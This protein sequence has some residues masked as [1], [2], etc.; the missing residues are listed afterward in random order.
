MAALPVA[1]LAETPF[2]VVLAAHHAVGSS[3]V[4]VARRAR[5]EKRVLLE[6][7]APVDC[8]SNLV[9]ETLS[10]FLVAAG[11]LDLEASNAALSRSVAAGR[12]LGEL[13]VEEGS[14][15]ADDLQR[16]LQQNLA[17]KL[18]DLFT[19]KDGEMRLESGEH[20]SE[21]GQRLKVQRLIVTGVERFMPQEAIDRCAA[22]FAGALLARAPGAEAWRAEVRPNAPEAALLDVLST[23]RR[24]DELI[25]FTGRPAEEIVRSIVA[26]ALV[27]LIA[28]EASLRPRRPA[29]PARLLPPGPRPEAVAAAEAAVAA[30]R[31]AETARRCESVERAHAELSGKDAFELL[32]ANED[33]DEPSIRERFETYSREY[34][35]WSFEGPDLAA[36]RLAARELFAAGAL[37]FAE[38]SDPKRREALRLERRARRDQAVRAS[39]ASYF[40]IET[41]LLDADVQ[42]QK[43]LAY[44]DQ[45]RLDLALQQ[46]EFASDCD[47]QNGVYAAETALCRFRMAPTVNSQSALESLKEAHRIDP[48]ASE[49]LLYAGEIC[50]ELSRFAEAEVNYRKAAKLLGPEDRR[51]LDAL[52]DLGQKKRRRR[53]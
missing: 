39:R 3:G 13:L 21:T 32:G 41:D 6:R 10:R 7:G 4:L 30:H 47:P 25:A 33:A 24:L 52:H 26:F 43:G 27:G 28:P 40:K 1:R 20:R 29:A 15:G 17:R 37:A 35:P 11:R 9:H 53:A 51:A 14:L 45:G 48:Q 19:W 36:A 31:T 49:P 12:L 46:F 22:P 42:Y 18:F 34:A 8:R 2:A 44:R 38:L 5:I 16:L 23:P 50:R